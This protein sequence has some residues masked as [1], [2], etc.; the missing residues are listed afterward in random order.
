[1]CLY[2][3]LV[4]SVLPIKAAWRT[5]GSPR[6]CPFSAEQARFDKLHFNK[7]LSCRPIFGLSPT[8]LTTAVQNISKKDDTVDDKKENTVHDNRENKNDDQDNASCLNKDSPTI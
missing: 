7:K 3:T 8:K 4:G 2:I 1:M 5:A 6:H